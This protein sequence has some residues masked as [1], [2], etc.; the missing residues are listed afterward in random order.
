MLNIKKD[1]SYFSIVDGII[2]DKEFN[3]LN[4]IEHH[5][6]SRYTHSVRVSYISYKICKLLKLDYEDAARAGLLH[7]FYIS[8][9]NRTFKER[10]T[11]TF[12]HPKKAVDHALEIYGINGREQDIIR[13]HMFPFT[14]AIPTYAES[15]IVVLVDKVIGSIEFYKKFEKQIIY[16]TNLFLLFIVNNIK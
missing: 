14:T 11:D 13:T 2:Y 3:K 5:G 4:E 1:E 12:T 8:K 10:F 7:D 9:E 15:W 16:T 6:I